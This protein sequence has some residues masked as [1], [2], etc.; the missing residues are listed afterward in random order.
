VRGRPLFVAIAANLAPLSYFKY[1][2][3]IGANINALTGSIRD[4]GHRPAL[5]ISFFTSRKSLSSSIL[6]TYRGYVR[7]F[8][9]VHY[10]LFVTYFPHL[11]AGPVLHHKEMMPQFAKPSTYRLDPENIA[12]GLTAFVIGLFKKVVLADG[13][14]AYAT[15]VF[16]A[17]EAGVHLTL[18]EARGG[19]LAYSFRSISTFRLFRH[20]VGLSRMFGVRRNQSYSCLGAQQDRVLASLADPV[21]HLR[22]YLHFLSG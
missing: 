6:S 13:I 12:V 22:D 14:A 8:N 11:I 1:A 10:M 5:G 21:A 4:R 16:N 3:F 9:F 2:G 19:V 15:P 7:E 20:G 18:F 17:A